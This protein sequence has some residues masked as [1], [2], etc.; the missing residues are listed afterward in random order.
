MHSVGDPCEGVGWGKLILPFSP[1]GATHF[2]PLEVRPY[3]QFIRL[4]DLL[5]ILLTTQSSKPLAYII[6]T[7]SQWVIL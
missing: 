5:L 4:N 7:I 1:P 6:C 2:T 3:T